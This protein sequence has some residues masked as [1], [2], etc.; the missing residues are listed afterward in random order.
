M[1]KYLLILSLLISFLN[2]NKLGIEEKL[3]NYV[4]L[5]L[6]F[7]NEKGELKTLRKLMDGKPTLLTLNYYRCAGICGPQLN[8]MAA[9]LSRLDL[10]ENSDY[11]VLT[12]SFAED[13]KPALA[14]AKRKNVLSSMTRSFVKDA[15]HFV[16]GKDGSS[17]QLAD[18]VGFNFETEVLSSGVKQ[19][20][21]GASLIVISPTG[22]ITRYL[23]GINQLPFDVKMSLI[24]SAEGKIGPTIAKT[25]LFCFAY[26]PKGKTYVFAWE[27]IAATVM[28]FIVFGFFIYLLKSSKK[29]R[30]AL[31]KEE[32]YKKQEDHHQKGENDE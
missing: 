12:V 4:S 29:T 20:I 23:N 10:V 17:K 6:K 11:K 31:T 2:A 16:I 14:R 13:E 25:L 5:D 9:M 24:E 18:S 15:W 22:K 8:D 3:G 1:A 26:D 32:Y 7:I 30:G 19:Y 21:H 27:K 28:L